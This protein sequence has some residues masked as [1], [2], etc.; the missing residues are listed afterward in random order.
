MSHIAKVFIIGRSQAV[1][2]PDEYRFDSKEIVIRRDPRTGDVILSRKPK[3][4]EEFFQLQTTLDIPQDFMTDRE[5]P[6]AIVRS[7]SDGK[8]LPHDA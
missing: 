5:D 7:T 4:W 8:G 1:R 6:P 2:L 3:D